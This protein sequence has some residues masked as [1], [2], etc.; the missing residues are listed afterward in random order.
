[1]VSFTL[2]IE[3]RKELFVTEEIFRHYENLLLIE[4]NKFLVEAEVYLF[5]PDHA[6]LL[7]RGAK[8][9]SNVLN[10]VKAYKQQSGFW[11]YQH[12]P[13]VHWQKDFY[14]HVER[15]EE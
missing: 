13:D 6:H 9:T 5:M 4:M 15:R 11:L 10:A 8:E 12:H 14:D 3:N 1:M 2:C 7:L